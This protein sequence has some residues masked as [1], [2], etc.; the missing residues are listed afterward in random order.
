MTEAHQPSQ[1]P[2]S[3]SET[4]MESP[5]AAS[6]GARLLRFLFRLL[7][8]LVILG[9][10]ISLVQRPLIRWAVQEALEHGLPQAGFRL[11][12]AKI[13]GTFG[14]A[15]VLENVEVRAAAD[16]PE[17]NET[18]LRAD[19]IE[20]AAPSI[21]NLLFVR[22][23]LTERLTIKGL[24][25]VLDQRTAFL[26]GTGSI[27]A[28]TEEEQAGI[29]RWLLLQLPPR[30]QL[31]SK[32]VRILSDAGK[33]Q[34][35][36]MRAEFVEGKIG[37]IS[38]ASLLI[39]FPPFQIETG[40]SLGKTAWKRGV[41]Y[42]AGLP[43]GKDFTLRNAAVDLKRPGGPSVRVEAD[44]FGGWLRADCAI[45]PEPRGLMVDFSMHAGGLELDP[46]IRWL[47]L[48]FV[49][50][51]MLP[52]LHFNY[53]G[54]LEDVFGG[55]ATLWLRI[56]DFESKGKKLESLLLGCEL[57]GRSVEIPKLELAQE[58]NRISATASL[59]VP[60]DGDWL[61]TSIRTD[62]R[63]EIKD[64]DALARLAGDSLPSLGGS[65]RI[66]AR[67][68]SERGEPRGSFS[69]VGGNLTVAG[70]SLGNLVCEADFLRTEID[71]KKLDFESGNDFLHAAGKF[72]LEEPFLYE[73][74]FSANIT[75]LQNL[76]L[77]FLGKNTPASG[78]I[79][80]E[81]QGDGT[82]N[83][84]SGGFSLRAVDLRAPA[85]PQGISAELEATYSPENWYFS[86]FRFTGKRLVLSANVSA[87]AAGITAKDLR[88]ESGKNLLL[89]GQL[90]LPL[91][92][93]A[94]LAGQPW[95]Q[96]ILPDKKIYAELRSKD[97]RVKELAALF[98]QDASVDGRIRL[99]VFAE[100]GLDSPI[101]HAELDASDL[102]APGKNG[103][104]L[105]SSANF[106]MTGRDG[107]AIVLG[108]VRIPNFQP[109]S[110][111][112]TFPFGARMEEGK[113][114]IADPAGPLR[115]KMVLPGTDLSA[116][117]SIIPSLRGLSGTLS[118]DITIGGSL[119]AP[120][121]LGAL[122]VKN[123]TFK[124]AGEL[125]QLT[126]LRLNLH[127]DGS[128]FRLENTGGE[129]GAG[130]FTISGGGEFKNPTNP[131]FHLHLQGERV[132]LVRNRNM[133]L[134]MNP[135]LTLRGNLSSAAIAGT[136]ALD[137]GRIY[138][139][140]ELTPLLQSMQMDTDA[141][142]L[143]PSFSGLVPP[144]FNAWSLNLKIKNANPFLVE[145]DLARGSIEPDFHIL[146]TLGDPRPAGEIT[147][148]DLVASLPFSQVKI[149]EGKI[150][151]LQSAPRNPLLDIRGSSEILN[152][153]IQFRIEGPLAE[154][155]L[156][157]R[158]D[159]P[160]SR[161]AILK[162]LLTGIAP[163]NDQGA[164]LGE[165]ALGQGG[166]LLLKPSREDWISARYISAPLPTVCKSRRCPL[167]Y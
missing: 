68:Q 18:L 12:H 119:L 118:G 155:N 157:L 112:L 40:T 22:E 74:R 42:L 107:I 166:L 5:P 122:H 8:L 95:T 153:E 67:V 167:S 29:S 49:A 79:S 50:K 9:A 2:A 91:S 145:G 71:L 21:W 96:G 56:T 82:R 45:D 46:A 158:S 27:P 87:G 14:R 93:L 144:P 43:L 62:A 25:L 36:A 149:P 115:G 52:E 151:L 101:L 80:I 109:L 94:A 117:A 124:P 152:Y 139:R 162:L 53:R 128:K 3:G 7:A 78:S 23:R 32:S 154:K 103:K 142:L 4:K 113:L 165:A 30:V 73:G 138:Q 48:S 51:G 72:T 84:H 147:I 37:E 47:G 77:P 134:R 159:P 130:A 127:F 41:M 65:L 61:R 106:K 39:D 55:F 90:F 111:E 104:L 140:L 54:A 69:V 125:P 120:E 110:L 33:I 64:L 97:W 38:L 135:D 108:E 24:D 133:R 137:E 16:A 60:S 163:G 19:R 44:A 66:D 136:I 86:K 150:F 17:G 123:G 132:L 28:P 57:A 102:R 26:P 156:I 83:S 116:L 141:P 31:E 129:I 34:L 63:A 89:F 100:G 161:E 35:G 70:A 148:R 6:K 20:L 92:P 10:I 85:F 98:G 59:L 88:L 131:S 143:L 121:I 126:S 1:K 164:G 105:A 160:L 81:W 76:L 114:Q 13:S 146:G 11:V 15:I 99:D 58:K 75:K